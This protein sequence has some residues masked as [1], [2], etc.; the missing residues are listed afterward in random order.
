MALTPA[1]DPEDHPLSTQIGRQ[2]INQV[3]SAEPVTGRMMDHISE[4]RQRLHGIIS[5]IECHADALGLDSNSA[6]APG[7]EPGEASPNVTSLM[8]YLE[9]D[10]TQLSHQVDRLYV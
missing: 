1:A 5:R 7:A 4:M 9:R 2:K 10:I 8:G 6:P 3:K